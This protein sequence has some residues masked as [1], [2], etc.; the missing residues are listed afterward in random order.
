[1]SKAKIIHV[2]EAEELQQKADQQVD[3]SEGNNCIGN[4]NPRYFERVMSIKQAK[5][6]NL[7]KYGSIQNISYF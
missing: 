7:A 3:V 1:M 6:Q 4:L 2:F 5:Q